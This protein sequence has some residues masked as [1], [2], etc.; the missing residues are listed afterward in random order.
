MDLSS[1]APSLYGGNKATG[2]E[3]E[4]RELIAKDLSSYPPIR[5]GLARPFV[6]RVCSSALIPLWGPLLDDR[7]V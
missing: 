1:E 5:E 3:R 6:I 2:E 4:N 7:T